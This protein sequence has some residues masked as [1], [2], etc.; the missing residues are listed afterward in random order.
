MSDADNIVVLTMQGDLVATKTFRDGAEPVG[1][2]KAK[3]FKQRVER[4][5]SLD[6]LHRLL[7]TLQR[8]R[9][10][11]VIRGAPTGLGVVNGLVRRTVHANADG[12]ACFAPAAPGRQWACFDFD[13]LVLD[14][15]LA[16]P[17][18]ND[19]LARAADFARQLLPEGF[20]SAA[21]VYRFSASAGLDGWD[22]VSLH[23]WFWLDRPVCDASLREWAA[24]AAPDEALF[25]P[26]QPHYVADPI[27]V[28]VPDPLVGGR[29]LGRLPGTAAAS[30]P[31]EWLDLAAYADHVAVEAE[32]QAAARPPLYIE[33]GIDSD[34]GRRRWCAKA[35]ESACE[36]VRTRTKATGRHPAAWRNAIAMGG[37]VGAGFLDMAMAAR[38]LT[39]AICSVVPKAR[40]AKEAASIREALAFGALRPRDLS[41]VA[42]AATPP[43]AA[44]AP[45][46][47]TELAA[48]LGIGGDAAQPGEE[49]MARFCAGL[50]KRVVAV[51]DVAFGAP[52][53]DGHEVP[54]GFWMHG[55]GL[56]AWKVGR[57]GLATPSIEHAPIVVTAREEDIETGHQ[58]L[59]VAWRGVGEQWQS[60]WLPREDALSRKG[61]ERHIGSGFPVTSESAARLVGYLSA[62]LAHNAK[63]IPA[64]ATTSAFGWQGSRG[65]VVGRTHI[66]PDGRHVTVDLEERRT[67]RQG[68][69]AFR[70]A[71]TDAGGR[72]M[73]DAL[74]ASGTFAAWRS[75]VRQLD[76]HPRVLF[77]VMVS[78]AAPLMQIVGCSNFLVDWAFRTSVG[79][80]ATFMAAASVW[81]DPSDEAGYIRPWAGTAVNIER[82]AV[83][84]RS[85]PLF[86]D[87]TAQARFPDIVSNAIYD[88]AKGQS[89]PRGN[90]TGTDAIAHFRLPILS[91]GEQP[92]TSFVEKGGG[93]A[94]CLEIVGLPFGGE[95]P[96][97]GRFVRD[98]KASVAA[99]HGHAGPRFVAA[100]L[101]RQDEWGAWTKRFRLM[102]KEYGRGA[103]SGAADRASDARALL[104]LTYDLA[105]E[106]LALGVDD[107][108]PMVWD[109]IATE[110]E[111]A[112]GEERALRRVVSWFSSMRSR[113]RGTKSARDPGP[114]GWL[115]AVVDDPRAK[116]KYVAFD[117]AGLDRF[118]RDAGFNP[119][120]MIAGWKA[121]GWLV[122]DEGARTKKVM[123]DGVRARL[124]CIGLEHFMSGT[125]AVLEAPGTAQVAPIYDPDSGQRLLQ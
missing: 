92:A 63:H 39:D 74:R 34:D 6:D 76:A 48:M 110:A 4:V 116:A 97:L 62:Y 56:G 71:E 13:D 117:D 8:R 23:L 85:V 51:T 101:A 121:R 103:T 40:H 100:L 20:R 9:Q 10:E 15:F 79:K 16:D 2:S 93:K 44:P 104:K 64:V 99:N 81:G 30:P 109:D 118:L 46:A 54:N 83:T 61:L 78:L 36:D 122:C 57:E 107:P 80:T 96:E 29:R 67:W 87:D 22:K 27:F 11:F 43:P 17:P 25:S 124:V 72:Q 19:D 120:A 41:R 50:D 115:G 84:L 123:I 114:Q 3:H 106:V 59:R 98:L 58:R 31:A 119:S 113:F 42:V 65:F 14:Q 5:A 60:R 89:K 102:A 70:A 86:L 90:K 26:V 125:D 95:T 47:A 69:V 12:P 33:G 49:P 68:A 75:A 55:R 28:D 66:M 38:A 82:T 73:A 1:Y 88:L 94:R 111:D 105:D 108:T 37:L 45:T 53:S 112:A 21:C 32:A 91:N 7:V 18:T 24:N 35:L 77:G 52:V